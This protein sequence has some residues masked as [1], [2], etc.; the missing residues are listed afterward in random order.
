[1]KAAIAIVVVLVL[2]GGGYALVKHND[3]NKTAKTNPTTNSANMSNM[4][5]SQSSGTSSSAASTPTATNTVAI[6]NFAFS[7][8]S[9]TVKKGT[10]VTWTNKDS[11]QH[12]VTENDGKD[13]PKSKLLAQGESYS[14]TFNTAGSFAYICSIHPNMTGTV[15]VTE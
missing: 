13:G 12:D 7:P 14:F 10:T 11:T 15:T 1:M 8:D 9:I 3:N 5:S 2:A 6:Q 4:S